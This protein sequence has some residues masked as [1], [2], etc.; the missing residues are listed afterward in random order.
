MP[1]LINALI[2]QAQKQE[3]EVQV[4]PYY[5]GDYM[6]GPVSTPYADVHVT[7]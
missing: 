7:V 5:L 4:N 6:P 2:A 1:V 3:S